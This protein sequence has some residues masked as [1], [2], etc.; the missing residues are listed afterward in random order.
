M[1]EDDES[2]PKDRSP[3][4]VIGDFELIEEIGSG[5][6]GVVWLARQISLGR[7]VALKVV[8]PHLE[9]SAHAIQ[10]FRLEATATARLQH[11][12][13]VPVHAVGEEHGVH[14]YAMD[15]IEGASL[16]QIL[17]ELRQRQ[18][19]SAGPP[20]LSTGLLGSNRGGHAASVARAVAAV[21]DALAYSHQHGIVHRDIKPGNLLFDRDGRPHIV[22][23]GLAKDL[24]L[25]SL[26]HTGRVVGTPYYMSPEQARAKDV[27]IDHRTDIFSLGVV[28]YEMLT[29]HRPFEG[30][31]QAEVLEAI[32]IQAPQRVRRL[33]P[34]VPRD[35]E[36]ICFK[37][38][39]KQRED[40]YASAREMADDLRRFLDHESIL[41]RP[42]SPPELARRF[43]ALHRTPILTA[44]LALVALV[45]GGMG[46]T[47]VAK[48]RALQR[49]LEPLEAMLARPDLVQASP[50]DLVHALKSLR[51]LRVA[52][53]DLAREPRA[54]LDDLETL[55]LATGR[56]SF[57]R[58][59]ARLEGLVGLGSQEL[60]LPWKRTDELARGLGEMAL[61]ALLLPEDEEVRERALPEHWYPRLSIRSE[62]SGAE[63]WLQPLDAATGIAAAARLLGR[64]PVSEL[65]IEPGY[66]RLT[67]AIPGFGS[68]EYTRAL[69]EL[70][71]ELQLDA[72]IRPDAQITLGMVRI[73]GGPFL[74]GTGSDPAQP[75]VERALEVP[76]YWIDPSEVSNADYKRFVDET[77]QRWPLAWGE[78]YDDRLASHPLFA[79]LPV[80][81]IGVHE[82]EAYAAW[83]GK[84]LPTIAEWERAARGTRGAKYPWGDEGSGI[85]ERANVD[86]AELHTSGDL[87]ADL[88]ASRA[89]YATTALP[90]DV[91]TADVSPDGILH[92]LGNAQEWTESFMIEIVEGVRTPV[93]AL[94]AGKGMSFFNPPFELGA[95]T[96]I[97]TNV[98]DFG[99]G[100]RCAK[101]VWPPT[102]R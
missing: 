97:P 8:Q 101:S 29:L 12:G 36:V 10:R 69:T 57:Q 21:A 51:A 85:V 20:D 35:L 86:R 25:E 27:T 55:I 82:A 42:P 47:A 23:F 96:A 68:A 39:E 56:E 83:A 4:R 7:M 14:W 94:R 28:L 78:S 26:I 90:V 38:M 79:R 50:D 66:Y 13:I 81:G 16:H 22:D 32:R 102:G 49:D 84:R 91:R 52:E 17:E 100:F 11:P 37:A 41:A 70:R 65:T 53:P 62:P 43:M 71:S 77:G 76:A 93:L 87:D 67:L 19:R 73:E 44:G 5:A 72:R 15:Y 74:F 33:N 2:P 61:A 89:L 63:V 99:L 1:A 59:E 45:A 9:L 98:R 64:T 6:M 31:S 24:N 88:D 75:Y 58:G 40:R 46:M 92:V 48:G 30:R 34:R 3:Y 54:T 60:A 80:T 95:T 18:E